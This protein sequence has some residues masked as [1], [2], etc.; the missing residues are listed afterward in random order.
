VTQDV[1]L[2]GDPSTDSVRRHMERM[3]NNP[4]SRTL[5]KA[6]VAGAAA[7]GIWRLWRAIA[8]TSW[9]SVARH[10]R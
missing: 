7:W 1:F 5:G 9:R 2:K 6:A 8:P 4:R 10:E 3:L